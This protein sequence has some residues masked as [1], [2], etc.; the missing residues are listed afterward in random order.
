MAF[1]NRIRLPFYVDR[2]QYPEER[3][4]FRNAAGVTKTL[5]VV[6]RKV[7]DGETDWM[8]APWHERLK[9]AL[10]HDN[11]T[12]EGDK[13]LTDVVQEGD[14]DIDWQAFL[15]YPTAPA[16]FK[17]QV[18]PF[19][20]TN[21]NCMS[22]EEANQL[23]LEDDYFNNPYGE[24][25]PLE[26]NNEFSLNV[27]DNDTI[28]CYPV[29]MSFTFFNTTYLDSAE[30]GPTGIVTIGTKS[31][32]T[33]ANNVLLA[34]YKVECPNGS[35]DTANIYGNINGSI[36][37]CLAPLNVTLQSS[38]P[39]S[40]SIV[41]DD[42]DPLPVSYEWA[43]YEAQAPGT[44]VL[45]GS[46]PTGGT[47]PVLNDLDDG[48]DYKFYVRSICDGGNSNWV[49]LLFTT[50]VNTATCG[51]YRVH[52]DDGTGISTNS[53]DITFMNCNSE[54]ETVTVFNNRSRVICAQQTSPGNP[55]DI[56]NA[57]S[58]DYE[59]LC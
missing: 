52:Y 11:V 15:H 32:L 46:E 51:K 9:I 54:Y 20:A 29:V 4:V 45:T 19:S 36:E 14:Y 25:I 49:E 3:S 24:P 39:T 30:I 7:L 57:T 38:S 59:G 5:S 17:V 35:F 6:I 47:F 1:K 2:P 56:I 22:C 16:K 53:T 10:S 37:G 58:I 42:P 41:W 43:L 27:T 34:T 28:C 33:S 12:I 8:P 13:Y 55:V 40:A 48:T 44:P 26:E 50:A 18:T 21:N 31:P 23:S